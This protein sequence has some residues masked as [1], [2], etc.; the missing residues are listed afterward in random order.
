MK[1][2]VSAR[3]GVM[4]Q[5]SQR[6]II[7]FI[8]ALTDDHVIGRDNQLPWHIP[9]DLAHFR[10]MTTGKPVVMGRRTYESIGKPLPNRHNIVITRDTSFRAEGCTVV[11]S[12][13][14]ALAAAGDVP[15]IMVIGGAEIFNTLLP[16]ADRLYLT[17]VHAEIEGDTFFPPLDPDAWIER[18]RDSH[19]VGLKTP[20]PITYVHYERAV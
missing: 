10:R 15:E 12:I 5:A 2:L 14:D 19:G 6:P 1:A 7:S 13:E 4:Q 20:Y 17:Y 8:V 16:R 18:Y 9:A 11:H 3:P